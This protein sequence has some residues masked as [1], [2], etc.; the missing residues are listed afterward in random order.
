ML[1]KIIVAY[2]IPALEG[3]LLLVC[4]VHLFFNVF[5]VQATTAQ[6]LPD[7]LSA[8]LTIFFGVMCVIIALYRLFNVEK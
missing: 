6:N 3:Y 5:T 2:F 4:S 7:M 8:V 1:K